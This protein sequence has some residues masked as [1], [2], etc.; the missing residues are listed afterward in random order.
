MKRKL[1]ILLLLIILSSAL[2]CRDMDEFDYKKGIISRNA[3]SICIS[4]YQIGE[5]KDSSEVKHLLIGINDPRISHN[6]RHNG[7]SVYYC[8]A[9]ALNKL[10]GLNLRIEQTSMPDT[11]IIDR[12]TRWALKEKLIL[13]SDSIDYKPKYLR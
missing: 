11:N 7:M 9:I 5:R 10:S 4:C 8:R 12:F 1:N 13:S 2:S 3:D 6:I